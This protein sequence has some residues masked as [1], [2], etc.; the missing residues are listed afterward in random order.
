MAD[1]HWGRQSAQNNSACG[2]IIGTMA[3]IQTLQGV[4]AGTWQRQKRATAGTMG[5]LQTLQGEDAC[6]RHLGACFTPGKP[7]SLAGT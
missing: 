3:F 2:A 7:R 6:T 4:H 1:S 5:L